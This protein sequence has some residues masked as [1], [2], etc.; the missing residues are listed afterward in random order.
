MQPNSRNTS[1][2]ATRRGLCIVSALATVMVLVIL[3]QHWTNEKLRDIT[4]GQAARIAHLEES[5]RAFMR[6]LAEANAAGS[7]SASED[8]LARNVFTSPPYQPSDSELKSIIRNGQALMSRK[9]MKREEHTTRYSVGGMSFDGWIA[10]LS[11]QLEDPPTSSSYCKGI[12]VNGRIVEVYRHKD[13]REHL[14][15][16]YWHDNRGAP[17][18]RVYYSAAGEPLEF[19]WADYDESI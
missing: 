1:G 12:Y 3:W 17:V 8:H 4:A 15:Q 9:A 10:A 2:R 18:L 13:N 14:E 6:K 11:D 19:H 5:S 16:K 7:S